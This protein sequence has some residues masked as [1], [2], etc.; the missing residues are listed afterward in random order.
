M[1]RWPI[2][3]HSPNGVSIVSAVFAQ[4]TAEYLLYNGMPLPPSKLPLPMGG[5]RPPSNTWFPEPTEV[6]NPNSISIG[7]AVLQG[8]LL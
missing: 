7:S 1:I 8:S 6:L 2:Q 5:S 4:M 3:A